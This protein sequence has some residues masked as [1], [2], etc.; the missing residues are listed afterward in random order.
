MN[1]TT[2]QDTPTFKP[3]PCR[4]LDLRNMSAN[5]AACRPTA[6]NKTSKVR[7]ND[8]MTGEYIAKLLFDVG[9]VLVNPTKPFDYASGLLSPLYIDYQSLTNHPTERSIVV[10][11]LVTYIRGLA[12]PL[13]IIVAVGLPAIPMATLVAERL[14]V[15]LSY[16]RASAKSHGKGKQIEGRIPDH[17]KALLICGTTLTDAGIRTSVS[18]LQQYGAEVV[19]CLAIFNSELGVVEKFLAQ[20]EIPF[21]SLTDLRTLLK[22]AVV[23]RRISSAEKVDIEEWIANPETW[24][25]SRQ[26]KLMEDTI[27]KRRDV[28]DALLRI[29]AVT[30]SPKRPYRFAS[31][32]MSPVYTDNRLLMSYPGEWECIM[33]SL[34][35]LVVNKVGVRNLDLVAGVPTSGI[36]HAVYLAHRLNLPMIY[37]ESATKGRETKSTVED[38]VLRNHRVLLVED[39]ISTGASAI[40]AAQTLRKSGATVEYC[41]AI[42]SYNL[43]ESKP[44]FKGQG[45]TLLTLSDLDS[46]LAVAEET[47]KIEASAKATIK[48]WAK[49]PQSWG[50]NKGQIF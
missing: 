44:S 41:V 45:I 9:A 1:I 28:A 50:P 11:A 23:E 35:S 31:G 7:C 38:Q 40:S 27:R 19:H 36:T 21:H 18:V 13:D 42:F 14:K 30:L 8:I 46:L 29:G 4:E 15:P 43:P 49:D 20:D 34:A 26:Q 5:N 10:D 17:C 33:D 47:K 37:V 3:R 2:G 25:D 48:E 6:G 22:V 32:I 39:L 16:V 24:H 12:A